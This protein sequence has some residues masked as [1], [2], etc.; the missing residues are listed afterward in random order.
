MSLPIASMADQHY[1][2]YAKGNK[3]LGSAIKILEIRNPTPEIPPVEHLD[4]LKA[5]AAQ[6]VADTSAANV[7]AGRR[8]GIAAVEAAYNIGL[9]QGLWTM[10]WRYWYDHER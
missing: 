7:V 10:T 5:A 2:I 9:D 4:N 3:C 8:L 6:H 1:L